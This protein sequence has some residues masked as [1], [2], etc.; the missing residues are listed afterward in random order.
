MTE[1]LK[2]NKQIQGCPYVFAASLGRPTPILK[3]VYK[4]PLSQLAQKRQVVKVQSA[5]E[6]DLLRFV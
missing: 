2:I 6:N 3:D 1:R 4:V 5:N